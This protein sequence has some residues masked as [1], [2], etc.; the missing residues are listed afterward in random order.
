MTLVNQG[1]SHMKD[2][3]TIIGAGMV[4]S[5]IAH[6]LILK[7]SIEEIALIDVDQ[8]F[9]NAQVLDLQHAVPFCGST[10]IKLGTYDDCA[11]SA[12][13]VICCGASQTS[14]Q[15]RLDLIKKNAA[16]IREVVPQVFTKNP[17]AVLVMVTNPV[18]VL[19]HLA[20]T[21]FPEKKNQIMGTG[22]MLDSARLR[23]LLGEKL[24]ISPKS[25]H[26]YIIG[27]HGDSELPLWSAATIGNMRIDTCRDL[28]EADKDAIFE[29]AK[30][31]AYT[32]IKGKQATYYAIGAA[33]AEL[34]EA[35]VRNKRNVLPVSHLQ[36]G[37][38]GVSDVCL[39]MPVVVGREGIVDKIQI[40]LTP[41]EKEQLQH[42]AETLKKALEQVR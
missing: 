20:I 1:L 42:S 25:I 11:D 33:G 40:T 3:V 26:A 34:V 7:E 38:H 5:T 2:K 23:H 37:E 16:I 13:V 4:G 6:S 39:S 10:K 30:S 15:T 31:A 22:T 27:E 21:L 9:A 24:N 18:D 41:E 19:T 29:Q 36:E 32:I 8:K 12:V 28:T 17:D 14:E 35:I